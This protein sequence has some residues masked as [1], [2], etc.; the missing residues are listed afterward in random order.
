MM[1]LTVLVESLV[2]RGYRDTI[3]AAE[4]NLVALIAVAET[5]DR[6]KANRKCSSN[7]ATTPR[8]RSRTSLGGRTAGV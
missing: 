1:K 4:A 6:L 3:R 8:R 2:A 5:R 7:A